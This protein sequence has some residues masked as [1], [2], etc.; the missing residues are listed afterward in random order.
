MN[1]SR[2]FTCFLMGG[3]S[4]LIQC[5]EILLQ[6]GHKIWGVI[7]TEPPILQWIKEKNLRHLSPNADI[8]AMLKEESFD[9]FFSINN[10]RK[11]P[12]EIYVTLPRMY[13]I[14]FHDGPLPRYA[15]YN[16]P[17]WA[18]M[19]QETMHGIAWHVMTD[20][21]DEGTILKQKTFSISDGETALTLNA[22]CYEE[23]IEGFTELIDEL[24]GDALKPVEQDLKERVFF[25]RWKRPYAACT[26][27]WTRPADEI[28][29]MFRALDY[30]T[31]PNPLG[32]PK[33]FLGDQAIVLKEMEVLKSKPAVMPGTITLLTQESINVATGTEEVALRKLIFFN[34]EPISPSAFLAKWGLREGDRL[35]ELKEQFADS[36]TKINSSLCRHEEYW[37]K[38]L[39]CLEPMEIPYAKKVNVNDGSPHYCEAR[40]FVPE[41]A[42]AR[43]GVWGL[44]GNVVLAA[45]LLYLAR[46]GGKEDFEVNYRDADLRELL[47]NTEI[48]FASHVP[49]RIEVDYG[50]RFEQFYEAIQQQ[51]ESVRPHGSFSRDLLFRDPFLRK[52][53]SGQFSG[54]LPVAVERVE[55][56]SYYEAKCDADLLVVIPDDGEELIWLYEEEALDRTAIERMH[57]QFSILLQ[58]IASGKEEPIAKLSILPEEER[59]KLLEEWNDTGR[60]YPQDICLHQLFEAQVER[61]PEAVA[62]VFEEKQLSYRELNNRANQLARHLKALGVGPDVLVGIFM[63]RSMEMVIGIYGVMKAGGAYVPLDPEYPPER[64]AFMAGDAQIPVLLTQEHLAASL[65][66]HKARVICL[67]SEWPAIA[68]KSLQNFVSGVTAENLAYVI[69]TSGST[70]VPKGAMNTHRGICNR[71]LSMQDTYRLTDGDRILQK[72]PFSFDVSV[73]EFFWPLLAGARLVVA[74]PGGHK[75]SNY[76][77]KTIQEQQITTLLFVPSMLQAFLDEKDVER[78]RSLKRVFCGGEALSYELQESFFAKLP[79]ELHNLYGPTEAAIGVTYWP[80]KRGSDRRIVPIGYPVANTQLYIVDPHLQ[81]VPIGVSGELLI[82]GVQVGRGYLNRPELTGEKFIPD[83]FSAAP[84]ARLY[85]TGDLARH[86]PGGEIEY[87][88]R[89]DDQVKIRGFRIELGEIEAVLGQHEA[90]REVVAMVREDV[91]GDKRLVAYIVPDGDHVPSVSVL[92]QY[93]KE[94]LPEYMLPGAF[95]MIEKFPLTPNGKIDRRALPSPTGLRPELESAYVAPRTDM[96]QTIAAIWQTVLRLEKIGIHDNF[97]EVGGYSLLATR[98]I[99]RIY[100]AFQVNL[101]LPSFFESPT[102][103]GLSQT[104]EQIK[105]TGGGFQVSPIVPIPRESRR[106]KPST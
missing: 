92:R 46:I 99:S 28:Y 101:S 94:K 12:R 102:V 6:K 33:L 17:N 21:I 90:I 86:L 13:A 95:V 67:D 76:L 103:A 64:V 34:G 60:D 47:S 98:V 105:N 82:G 48:F 68:R 29:A 7:S 59:R 79:A 35:P 32:L 50:Q 23:S 51:I 106:L 70:G 37:I 8:V 57:Q 36:L 72:T 52:E 54:R 1:E 10:F 40:F 93:L 43:G 22:K 30:G 9:I 61:T 18:L 97:F 69:Y 91:P 66:E 85:R 75:D 42:L 77:V 31:Y 100:K 88:G 15:G 20:V 19:N 74:R 44:P 58:D 53:F 84:G 96:E 24:W 11:V 26:V 71:L 62:V 89:I 41:P 81:Q 55:S 14:N 38:R 5:G 80:C 78:C 104:I 87:L 49:L 2:R 65:P 16:T 63:E 73:R 4:R 45:F 83:P 56:L 25:S 27:D 3:S 39:A